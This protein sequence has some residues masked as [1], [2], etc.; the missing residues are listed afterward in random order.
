MCWRRLSAIVVLP[1]LLALVG[2]DLDREIEKLLGAIAQ[3]FW[4]LGFERSED[5]LLAEL[6]ET[7]GRRV[8]EVSPRKDMPIKFRVLNTGEVNA[9]ALPNGRIY[10][11][12][13]MLETSDTEDEL[14]AV[15][16]HEVGHVAGRHSLKQFRLSLGIGLLA[17]LLNL[18][19]R[20]ETIQTLAGL[21]TSLY[22]LGYSR[23]HERDADN[24][25]LRLALLAGYD[26][27]GSVALF[28]KF[29]K[30]EGKP[31][32]W[33]IYLSTHPPSTERLERAKRANED[34]GRIY[35]DLPAFAAHAMVAAGYA[36]RGLYRHA[37]LH[38]EAAIKLQPSYVPA[39][40]GL[41]QAREE[42]Q[43]WDEAK[44][45][46][47]RALKLEPQNEMARQGLERVKSASQNSAPQT[48]H[49]ASKQTLALKWL[50]R[51]LAEWEQV[52][53]QWV[54]GQQ[55]ASNATGNAAIQV[56]ALWSQMRSIPLRS[57]PISVT[58]SQS[59]KR[60]Q[61]ETMM[62]SLGAMQ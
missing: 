31:A 10:V 48:S 2:C 52:E 57:G 41:A 15:L 51:A 61:R 36:Q 26:P 7:T 59:E 3:T 38:Y 39:A 55:T 28:E 8:A 18:N 23:Q 19:K 20:G 44:K 34:L 62:F 16:A 1:L 21:A 13:G 5:P 17:D 14:A 35:P 43:E 60:D 24:Y 22:E 45:W 49:P 29:A 58:F 53:R 56:K 12:R 25:A 30:N 46:Y 4:E 54:E 50:E 6:T 42:L 27:K 47:E 32:R 9:V 11:F 33:L 37:A 40:L